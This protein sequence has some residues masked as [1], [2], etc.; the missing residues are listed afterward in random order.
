MEHQIHIK[1]LIAGG[2]GFGTLADGMV[3]MVPGVLPGETVLVRESRAYRGHKEARLVRILEASPNRIEPACP[4]YGECGGCDL[5]HANYP[6]QL[7]IKG[8]IVQEALERVHLDVPAQ[9]PSPVVPSPQAFGYRS[10]LRLHLDQHGQLGFHQVAS[11]TVVPI[12]ACLLA[13]PAINQ[14]IDALTTEIWHLQFAERF[15][16]CIAA[17][18]LIHSPDDDRVLL[19]LHA[20]PGQGRLP[21]Q[22]DIDQL[23]AVAD[24]VILMPGGATQGTDRA[25]STGHPPEL[26]QLPHLSQNFSLHGQ[27]WQLAWNHRCFFQVNSQQTTPIIKLAI[28]FLAQQQ[29]PGNCLDLFCGMG[30]FSIPLGLAGATVL[31]IEHNRTSIHWAR[32]NAHKAGLLQATFIAADVER[33][34]QQLLARKHAFANIL[35]DP[36]RQGLGKAAALLPQFGAERIV[37]VSCDPATHARDLAILL[38]NGY[39]LRQIIPVDMFPQTHHIESLALL[40]RN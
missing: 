35:L 1:K 31:G 15:A 37:S 23:R 26:A 7:H 2:K 28:D 25:P 13:V 14:V 4:H 10:R 16:G 21:H 12:R 38:Q 3:V 17:L 5:Q 9:Q 11:N 30:T 19:V 8:H 33:Q 22:A 32:H 6:T 40:E 24:T 18:E 27:S 36:P 39:R 34:V 20:H 29:V